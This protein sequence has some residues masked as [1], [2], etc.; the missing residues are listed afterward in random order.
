MFTRW[1]WFTVNADGSPPSLCVVHRLIT[2]QTCSNIVIRASKYHKLARFIFVDA[3]GRIVFI[4]TFSQ[5]LGNESAAYSLDLHV[6][7][8]FRLLEHDQCFGRIRSSVLISVLASI[9][10]MR[11]VV[12]SPYTPG[13][14]SFSCFLSACCTLLWVVDNDGNCMHRRGR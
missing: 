13:S 6:Q 9:Y 1:L 10:Y 11:A 4:D 14:I 3:L 7:H 12:Y 2:T 8:R 5:T